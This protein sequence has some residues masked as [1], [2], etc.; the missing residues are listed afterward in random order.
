MP[1]RER[2]RPLENRDRRPRLQP[3]DVNELA[4]LHLVAEDEVVLLG[5][6]AGVDGVRGIGDLDVEPV[7]GPEVL[8]VEVGGDDVGDLQ[9]RVP[10]LVR[11]LDPRVHSVEE[12]HENPRCQGR[13]GRG[14]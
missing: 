1:S 10:V 14:L 11:G 13:H 2:L 4:E 12:L 8:L 7:L 5:G 6:E 9:E 3:V